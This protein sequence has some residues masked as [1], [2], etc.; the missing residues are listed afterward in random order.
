[1]FQRVFVQG[2]ASAHNNAPGGFAL[3]CEIAYG[4][5]RP[6]PCEGAALTDRVIDDCRR[7][8]L[9]GSADPVHFASQLDLPNARAL[10]DPTQQ[11]ALLLIRQWFAEHDI[12]L[13]GH[14]GRWMADGAPHAFTAGRQAAELVLTLLRQRDAQST[15]ALQQAG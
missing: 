14:H 12:V 15:G 4:P 1:V 6:L 7:I 13:A 11:A 9:F 8:G 10:P 3:A 5:D 2:N